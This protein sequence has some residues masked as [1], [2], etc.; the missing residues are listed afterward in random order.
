MFTLA[1]ALWREDSN[2]QHTDSESVVLPLN[3]PTM[4]EGQHTRLRGRIATVTMT[5]L[6][7][8]ATG[9]RPQHL[10]PAQR[11]WIEPELDRVIERLQPSGG[12]SGMALGV[13]T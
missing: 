5:H 8:A 9:H 1:A 3:Y 11:L 7:V 12:I 2:L 4:C 13:D 6:L 10:S